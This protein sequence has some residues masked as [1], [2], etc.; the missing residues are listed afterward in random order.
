MALSPHLVAF[1]LMDGV[2]GPPPSV[3]LLV[4][5]YYSSTHVLVLSVS[6][7]LSSEFFI[8]YQIESF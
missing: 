8:L 6:G 4:F 5:Y 2:R 3:S 7:L 1:L